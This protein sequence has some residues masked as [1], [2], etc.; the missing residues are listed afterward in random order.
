[1]SVSVIRAEA[2]GTSAPVVSV[3]VPAMVAVPADWACSDSAGQ[4]NRVTADARA[5]SRF[6]DE[7]D[8]DKVR[9]IGR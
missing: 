3:T 8:E 5:R 4:I 7:D 9:F 2:E 6:E 1:V